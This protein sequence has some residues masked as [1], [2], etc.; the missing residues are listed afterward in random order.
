[1]IQWCPG[2]T[3]FGLFVGFDKD[4]VYDYDYYFDTFEETS[5]VG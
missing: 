4:V 5:S 3:S 1:M 2:G